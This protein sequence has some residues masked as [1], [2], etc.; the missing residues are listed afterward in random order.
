MPSN[1]WGEYYSQTADPVTEDSGTSANFSAWV[2]NTDLVT[3][4]AQV[5]PTPPASDPSGELNTQLYTTALNVLNAG[6][7]PGR[8]GTASQNP[9][10]YLY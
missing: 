8:P 1:Q 10:G 2:E 9:S 4:V 3:N 5:V 7:T 6:T